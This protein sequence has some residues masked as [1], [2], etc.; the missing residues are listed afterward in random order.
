MDT[1]Q[2]G[3]FSVSRLCLGAMTY[4]DPAWRSWVL[5]EEAG[6][7]FVKRALEYGINFFEYRRHVF[8]RQERGSDAAGDWNG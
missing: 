2:L 4:G 8:A 1:A 3:P 6:R 5:S 7:P